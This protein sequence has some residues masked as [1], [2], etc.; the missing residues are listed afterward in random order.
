MS[1]ERAKTTRTDVEEEETGR[2]QRTFDRSKVYLVGVP[3]VSTFSVAPHAD[4]RHPK[5]RRL[6]ALHER[7]WAQ[8]HRRSAHALLGLHSV[9][10]TLKESEDI[11]RW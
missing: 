9:G 6:R 3:Q 4:R 8:D 10:D 5:L 11:S 2:H 7:R 1:S